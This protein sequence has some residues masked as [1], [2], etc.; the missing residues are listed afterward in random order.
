VKQMDEGMLTVKR[1]QRDWIRE[2]VRYTKAA[3]VD[4]TEKLIRPM[5]MMLDLTAE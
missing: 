5:K 4:R 1:L 2:Y 3:G